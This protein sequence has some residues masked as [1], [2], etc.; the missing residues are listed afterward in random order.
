MIV[1]ADNYKLVELEK[2]TDLEKL[3]VSDSLFKIQRQLMIKLAF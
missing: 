1:E 3:F 2:R